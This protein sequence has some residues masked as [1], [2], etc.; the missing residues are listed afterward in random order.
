MY[1]QGENRQLSDYFISAAFED[2]IHPNISASTTEQFISMAD[3]K[4]L[5]S[6]DSYSE[7]TGGEHPKIAA[8]QYF[9][10]NHELSYVGHDDADNP[11][12]IHPT[13]FSSDTPIKTNPMPNHLSNAA[14]KYFQSTSS[15]CRQHCRHHRNHKHH[16]CK[17]E[18]LNR[19]GQLIQENCCQCCC[20]QEDWGV[21]GGGGSFADVGGGGGSG[22]TGFFG[23]SGGG[24][25]GSS[26]S[27]DN[28]S[29]TETSSTNTSSTNTTSET[30]DN[31]DNVGPGP[32]E[33][34][35]PMV[36]EP[37]T[38]SM[39][40]LTLLIGLYLKLNKA[41]QNAQKSKD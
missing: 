37:S 7:K 30:T 12:L 35:G 29:T 25:G 39:L 2:T 32:G 4:Y 31:T 22:A 13:P 1:A 18:T 9:S 26:S 40:G 10:K 34:T 20:T 41:K 3:N 23:S 21:G 6:L 16:S 38:Y 24:G 28:G 36:P 27:S 33:E 11:G 17:A 14:C 5:Y 19:C 15:C 8:I